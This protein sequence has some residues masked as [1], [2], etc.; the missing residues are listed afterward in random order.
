MALNDV[1]THI[2]NLWSARENVG[3]TKYR[4]LKKNNNNK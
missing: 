2:H 4:K 1:N 3:N